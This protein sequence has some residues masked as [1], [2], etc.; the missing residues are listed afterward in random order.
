MI[1]LVWLF[2]AILTPTTA[3]SDHE[4]ENRDLIRGQDLYATQC[5][6]CHGIELQGQPNWKS[7]DSNGVLPAPPHDEHGHTWHHDNQLLFTYTKLGG[8]GALAKRGITNF[9][10]GMPGYAEVMTDDEIWDVLAYIR[11]TWP[12]N[13]QEYQAKRNF[14]HK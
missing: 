12:E 13:I 2:C 8:Q 11:S 6:S 9:N 10:S 14:P 3:F 5:A 1:R 4:L 7:P